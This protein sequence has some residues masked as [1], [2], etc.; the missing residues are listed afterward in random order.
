MKYKTSNLREHENK[1]ILAL[2]VPIKTYNLMVEN[3]MDNLSLI[4][5]S[6]DSWNLYV[7]NDLNENND[8]V[9]QEIINMTNIHDNLEY[10]NISD[11]INNNKLENYEENNNVIENNESINNDNDNI[12]EENK[13]SVEEGEKEESESKNNNNSESGSKRNESQYSS[14]NKEEGI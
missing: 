4:S 2:Q 6:I 7:N 8:N 11:V 3:N 10:N 1:E 12:N 5:Q 13:N 14:E 9:F